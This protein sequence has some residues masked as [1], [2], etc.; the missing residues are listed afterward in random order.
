MDTHRDQISHKKVIVHQ[1]GDQVHEEQVVHDVSLERRQDIYK[2]T[3]LLWL[4]VGMLESLIAFR[5][6]LK[7]IAA[8]PGSWFTALVYQ[9]SDIFVWPFQTITTNPSFDGHVLEIT[10]VIAM[11]VYL[12]IGLVVVRLVWLVFYRAPTSRVTV[13]DRDEIK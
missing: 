2:V 12:L 1:Q 8:N 5:L 4:F 7:V 10:S 13:Y 6:F 9:L 3:Q 11:F